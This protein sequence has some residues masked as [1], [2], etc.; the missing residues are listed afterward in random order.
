MAEFSAHRLVAPS[1]DRVA[2]TTHLNIYV[3]NDGVDTF[4]TGL[5]VGS[6]FKTLSGAINYLKDK[7]I[8]DSGFVTI[9]FARGIY[10]FADDVVINHPEGE[11]IAIVGAE[12]ETLVL[13]YVES[14]STQGFTS[15]EFS[16]Y[17]SAVRHDM[18]FNCVKP[19][20][21]SGFVEIESTN[22]I[23]TL[24]TGYGVIVED[25][26]LVYNDSYNPISFYSAFPA[27]PRNN[28][29]R[30]ASVL[31]CHR[32]QTI[33]GVT[34]PSILVESFVRDDWMCLP[35]AGS[36]LSNGRMYGNAQ[37][38]VQYSAGICGSAA[39]RSEAQTNGWFST[40]SPGRGHFISSVP[41]GYYGKQNTSGMPSAGTANLVGIT[42]PIGTTAGSTASFIFQQVGATAVGFYTCS[43]TTTES[44]IND[45]ILF[46][47]NYHYWSS[48]SNSGLGSSGEWR[49]NNSNTITVKIL[50]TVFRRFGN[51][52]SINVSG[53]RKI[54]NI[55]FDGRNM[56]Y[57]YNMIS[58]G[59]SSID[60]YSNKMAIHASNSKLGQ[61]IPNEPSGLG[62]GLCSNVGI[63][64]F[65]TAVYCDNHSRCSLG[66]IIASNC[67][68]GVVV[69][70]GSTL[71]TTGSVC[72]G[73]GSVAYSAYNNSSMITERCY[74]GFV[75]N[76]I[77][78]IRMKSS[79]VTLE[80]S[81]FI[82]GQTFATP[83]G[84]ITGT[85]WDW[86]AREKLLQIAVRV[87][88]AEGGDPATQR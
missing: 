13:R 4:N 14:Y 19:N 73:I 17:Y 76:S 42:Y 31:G 84:K 5:D 38:N 43:G 85:V 40:A 67:S 32:L 62:I 37:N 69:N 49:T 46:G 20:D 12:P 44:F 48:I 77:V 88:A 68:F 54:K 15:T 70:N 66:K 36:N 87:G 72:T 56:Y 47:N 71:L 25:Y 63:A 41:V 79:G 57:H 65:H 59:S 83:D 2:I 28:I 6:P 64:N 86:N 1:G 51:I 61:M 60:G 52:L 53:L 27:H 35:I 24:T 26:D 81:S 78:S 8:S 39:D 3:S 29:V 16:N 82:P 30:T 74:A 34:S 7:Y 22:P 55:F 33:T 58:N 11:R 18:A 75:G 10:D 50:P 9:N 45:T 80:D 23:T 21:T